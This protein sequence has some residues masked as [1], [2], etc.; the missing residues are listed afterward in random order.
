MKRFI[1]YSDGG[2]G[3]S[4]DDGFQCRVSAHAPMLD[5]I[6][7]RIGIQGSGVPG[8][9]TSIPAARNV[10]FVGPAGPGICD[11]AH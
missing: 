4:A 9:G 11:V 10:V 7:M 8:G 6:N 2:V 1:E 5:R 3:R